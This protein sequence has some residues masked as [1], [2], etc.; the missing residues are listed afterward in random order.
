MVIEIYRAIDR[1]VIQ[2]DEAAK[3]Y[4]YIHWGIDLPSDKDEQ[5]KEFD[6]TFLLR[7]T[8]VNEKFGEQTYDRSFRVPVAKYTGRSSFDTQFITSLHDVFSRLGLDQDTVLVEKRV[9]RMLEPF[10]DAL[11]FRCQDMKFNISVITQCFA[12]PI[13]ISSGEYQR[14][15]NKN[16]LVVEGEG[17]DPLADSEKPVAPRLRKQEV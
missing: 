14:L 2:F 11:D 5:S 13:A 1:L 10:F 6:F 4:I 15:G 17:D 7:M 9:L 12:Q 8:A 3:A 16:Y